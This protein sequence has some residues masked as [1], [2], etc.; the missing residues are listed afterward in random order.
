MPPGGAT[1]PPAGQNS[2]DPP[3]DTSDG[4]TKTIDRKRKLE[5]EQEIANIVKEGGYTFKFGHSRQV[6]TKRQQGS[7][8]ELDKYSVT[9]RATLKEGFQGP[10][11]KL[12]HKAGP[13]IGEK[14]RLHCSR[15]EWDLNRTRAALIM[16]SDSR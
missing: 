5:I 12:T 8:K 3:K 7:N 11:F 2:E 10:S 16:V 1:T 9:I 15:T 4:K 13:I 14:F 6:G